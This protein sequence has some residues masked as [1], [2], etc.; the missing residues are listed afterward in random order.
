MIRILFIFI[1]LTLTGF[2]TI[3]LKKNP[4]NI[5][6]EW[7]GWLLETSVPIIIALTLFLFFL[8]IVCY[9]L[10]KKIISIPQSVQNR[11]KKNKK[12]KA[13][14]AIIKAFSAKY[15]G[16]IELAES[17]S[18]QAK[19]LN[20][21]PLKLLLD[22]EINN[23]YG[24]DSKDLEH[25]NNMLEHP[26]TLL[27]SVKKLTTT[28]IKNRE[29]KDALKIISMSPKSKNTPK[30]FF[31]TALQLNILEKNWEKINISIKNINKYTNTNNTS[32]K[33]IKSRI[34][35]YKAMEEYNNK[36]NDIEFQDINTSLKFDPSFAPAIVLKA[37]LLYK[38]DKKLGL[39][40]IKNSWKKHSHPEI[41]NFLIS[42]FD[43]KPKQKL[44]SI[45]KSLTK[46]NNDSYNNNYTLA[47]VALLL[48]AWPIARQALNI[49][50]EKNWT[51]TIY[52]MMADLEKKE[53]GDN[54][55]FN[56]WYDKAQ[57]AILDFSW[58]CTSCSYIPDQW[59]LICP[60]CSSLDSIQWQQFATSSTYIENIPPIIK[61]SKIANSFNAENAARGIIEELNTG[62][63]R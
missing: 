9:F 59:K 22:S 49:I 10:I 57:N 26:E 54:N 35:L 33:L 4:G 45:V 37:K 29:I 27:V 60:K 5:A 17:Y 21:T 48:E 24:N 46:L 28:H 62:M 36:N 40:Y 52:L 56:F 51:K 14:T 32:L 30:W 42:I 41:A 25:L 8:V 7:Q 55:K 53:H 18:K 3:W 38:N 63:D 23:Y 11:Y 20:N 39:D 1:I 16:E 6:I 43:N 12:S 44:L 61:H 31:Y 47:K 15:M 2:I 19:F 34:F 58:G 50:P 13:D